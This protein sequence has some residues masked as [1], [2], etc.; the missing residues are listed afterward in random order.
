MFAAP[1]L[2]SGIS[3]PTLEIQR[4]WSDCSSHFS[5]FTSPRFVS[6]GVTII[7]RRSQ[8]AAFTL[9]RMLVGWRSLVRDGLCREHRDEG[10][11]MQAQNMG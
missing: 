1:L 8:V 10:N 5:A 4:V 7:S 6:W 11:M 3:K 9:M 2:E